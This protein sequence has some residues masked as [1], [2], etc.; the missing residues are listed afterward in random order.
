MLI[1]ID[2]PEKINR[3]LKIYKAKNGYNNMNEVIVDIL[4]SRFKIKEGDYVY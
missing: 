2:I 4:A 3:E 1:Q